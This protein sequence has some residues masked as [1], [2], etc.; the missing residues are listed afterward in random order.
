M[1]NIEAFFCGLPSVTIKEKAWKYLGGTYMHVHQPDKPIFVVK[2]NGI[3]TIYLNRPEKR[4][5]I[6]MD[7]WQELTEIVEEC[8]KDKDVRVIVFRSTDPKVFSAGADIGEF[9]TLRNNPENGKKYHEILS[10]FEEKL[11]FLDKPSIA[12]I[13]G[14]CF[15]GG[16]ELAIACDFRFSDPTGIFSIPAAKLGIIYPPKSTKRLID[17][18]GLAR[19]KEILL[20]G[21]RLNAHQ[22]LEIGLIHQIFDGSKLENE[23]YQFARNLAENSG[24]AIRGMK[25]VIGLIMEGKGEEEVQALLEESFSSDDYKERVRTFLDR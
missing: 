22:A 15:G 13:Q 6:N 1:I 9:Q 7:M 4:N 20:T 10:D 2:E 3:G 17:L 16:L 11:F 5:A 21:K 25:K 12:M 24:L 14:Y 8:N 18:V 19:T 23:I